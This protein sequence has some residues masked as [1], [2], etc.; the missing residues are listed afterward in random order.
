MTTENPQISVVVPV[1]KVERYLPRCLDSILAQSFTD[2]E[3][4]LIDDGSPDTCGQLC[5]ESL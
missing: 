3:C 4:I 2:W 1:Y 5:D